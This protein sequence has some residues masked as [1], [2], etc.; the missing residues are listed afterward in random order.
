MSNK[1]RGVHITVNEARF[2]LKYMK[3]NGKTTISV[4][5]FHPTMG[6]VTGKTVKIEAPDDFDALL[7]TK[8]IVFTPNMWQQM[9]DHAEGL[10]DPAFFEI[11]DPYSSLNESTDKMLKVLAASGA[12][13]S[14][15]VVIDRE[16]DPARLDQVDTKWRQE[17]PDLPDCV[18]FPIQ[19]ELL[20][21]GFQYIGKART[22]AAALAYVEEES[23][24]QTT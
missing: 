7:N 6:L 15:I 22:F 8:W 2:I 3:D 13:G 17:H 10:R 16:Q 23:K 9:V 20:I 12:D 14:I 24:E 5:A 11:D 19:K 21:R 1:C 4:V 18:P